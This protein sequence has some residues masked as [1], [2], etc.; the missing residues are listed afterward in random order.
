MSRPKKIVLV[1][2]FGV[3]KTS[4][5]RRFVEDTFTK[6]YKVTIGVHISKKAVEFANDKTVSLIIWDLEGLDDISKMRSSYLLGTNGFIY[7]F[8]LSRPAT[9][10]HLETELQFLKNKYPNIPTKVVGNKMDLVNKA[11]IKQNSAVFEPFVDFFV[12][13]KLGSRVETLFTKLAE[14]LI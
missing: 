1:G 13:A 2:H 9:Y 7:V 10:E 3:G 6:D 5:I 8:D 12:S 11:F 4:L 14:A